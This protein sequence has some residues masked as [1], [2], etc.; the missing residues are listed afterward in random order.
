MQRLLASAANKVLVARVDG[1]VVPM[2]TLVMF[3]L[4]SGLRARI[5]DVDEAAR[6]HGVGGAL[7]EE[8]LRLAEAAGPRTVDLTSRPSDIAPIWSS[9]RLSIFTVR[10]SPLAPSGSEDLTRVLGRRMGVLPEIEVSDG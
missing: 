1:E 2:L 4:P 7:T 9:V 5:E 6:G 3:P 8:A 10:C